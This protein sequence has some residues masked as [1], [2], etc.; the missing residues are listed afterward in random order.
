MRL[1]IA[2]LPQAYVTESLVPVAKPRSLVQR[3]PAC[4]SHSVSVLIKPS[5]RSVP[6]WPQ[7]SQVWKDSSATIP[8]RRRQASLWWLTQKR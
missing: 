1:K 5:S 4:G 3:P 7:I 2:R 8:M 6:G